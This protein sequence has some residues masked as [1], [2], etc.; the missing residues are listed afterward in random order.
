MWVGCRPWY[1]PFVLPGSMRTRVCVPDYGNED[2]RPA[3]EFYERLKAQRR[4]GFRTLPDGAAEAL[5]H[6]ASASR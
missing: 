3:G 4:D 2:G 5:E 6:A 1:E